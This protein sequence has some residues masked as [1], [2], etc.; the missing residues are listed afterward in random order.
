[1]ERVS[2]I[3]CHPEGALIATEGSLTIDAEILR[4]RSHR[5]DVLREDDIFE[6][7]C[8]KKTRLTAGG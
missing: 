4:C 1:M 5:P 6:M 3:P 8:Y 2:K 7:T